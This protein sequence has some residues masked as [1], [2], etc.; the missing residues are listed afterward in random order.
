MGKLQTVSRGAAFLVAVDVRPGSPTLGK[1]IGMTVSEQDRTL[2]W[3]PAHFARGFCALT[4]DVDVDYLCTG[5]YNGANESAIRWDDP[6]VGIE[7]PTDVPVLS[8]KDRRAGTLADWL[9]RPESRAF[10]FEPAV[11]A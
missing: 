2:I 5:T 1:W 3:A 7:W 10:S 9:Q 11:R 6:A 4:D 8:D